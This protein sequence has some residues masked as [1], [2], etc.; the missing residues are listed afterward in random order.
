MRPSASCEKKKSLKSNLNID[1]F[2]WNT[3]LITAKMLMLSLT[4]FAFHCRRKRL[5]KKT[6]GTKCMSLCRH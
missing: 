1:I 2:T 5:R 6:E 3:V 4:F